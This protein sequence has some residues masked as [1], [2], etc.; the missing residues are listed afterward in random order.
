[1]CARYTSEGI[2]EGFLCRQSRGDIAYNEQAAIGELMM[3][4]NDL[5]AALTTPHHSTNMLAEFASQAQTW[6]AL[7]TEYGYYG[8]RL[9]LKKT[10]YI[11]ATGEETTSL[12]CR[13]SAMAYPDSRELPAEHTR[14]KDHLMWLN[15]SPADDGAHPPIDLISTVDGSE[16]HMEFRSS[17]DRLYLLVYWNPEEEE[18]L[19]VVNCLVKLLG[20]NSTW[21]D[22]IEVMLISEDQD[23]ELA[24]TTLKS[25]SW[26]HLNSYILASSH[27]Q[28]HADFMRSKSFPS[29]CF[30][31]RS[32]IVDKPV[33]E[34]ED[35]GKVIEKLLYLPELPEE[36]YNAM[37]PQIKAALLQVKEDNPQLE[38]YYAHFSIMM[39]LRPD[40]SYRS[41]C[42]LEAMLIW[43]TMN[44]AVSQDLNVDLKAAF[45][46]DVVIT[47]RLAKSSA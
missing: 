3:T 30:I 29:V 20:S 42:R 10:L 47:S 26:I 18:S 21:A 31:R 16:V 19:T 9:F 34:A 40:G 15:T 35:L 6:F 39:V 5:I 41:K 11:K 24:Q 27:K 43:R 38:A 32:D 4:H 17:D 7:A 2:S 1:V 13:W 28:T 8:P 45:P 36:E 22:Q 37:L 23:A 33:I 46:I 14:C 44:D 25:N 12:A